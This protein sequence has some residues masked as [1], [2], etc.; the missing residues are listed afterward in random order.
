MR[1]DN[2]VSKEVNAST[3]QS[4]VGSLLYIAMGTR[5]D[6]VQAVGVVSKYNSKPSEAR[7]IAVK[8]MF[9]Y[10]KGTL[11]Y[12]LNYEQ[13]SQNSIPTLILQAI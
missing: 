9:Q 13:K 10:L 5:P 7:L 1:K 11:D 4:M 12:T 2:G 8:R 6:I 3:Y